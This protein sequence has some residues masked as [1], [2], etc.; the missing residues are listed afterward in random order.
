MLAD[1]LNKPLFQMA[2][3]NKQTCRGVVNIKEDSYIKPL[4]FVCKEIVINQFLSFF[5]AILSKLIIDLAIVS[6]IRPQDLRRVL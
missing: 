2:F 4:R 3:K 1:G 5:Y 6:S